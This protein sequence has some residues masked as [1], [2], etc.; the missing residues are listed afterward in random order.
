MQLKTNYKEEVNFIVNM[1]MDL[2]PGLIPKS[3]FPSKLQ[4]ER[5]RLR[6]EKMLKM[7]GTLDR[8]NN[9][10]NTIIQ[11]KNNTIS[12]KT[13]NILIKQL[14][15][16]GDDCVASSK[17]LDSNT[18]SHESYEAAFIIGKEE[19]KNK[20]YTN[21]VGVFTLLCF[22]EPIHEIYWLCLGV[23]EQESKKFMRAI[24]AYKQASK[25]NPNNIF[26]KLLIA[27]CLIELNDDFRGREILEEAEQLLN[28][29]PNPEYIELLMNL[30]LILNTK[31]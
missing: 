7:E 1:L 18:I 17:T 11:N 30:K 26:Y 5:Q 3:L 28:N 10:I 25:I 19:F 16:W 15:D 29:Y 12:Q 14:Q 20:N 13:I 23:A 9:G 27:E 22:L 6:Y 8:I 24:R 21:A 4:M 2:D 31:K